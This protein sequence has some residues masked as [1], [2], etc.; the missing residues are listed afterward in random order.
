M[1]GWAACCPLVDRAN[2]CHRRA[3][4][5]ISRNLCELRA[6]WASGISS[7]N[8]DRGNVFSKG[9]PAT[10]TD[11]TSTSPAV[12]FTILCTS[13]HCGPMVIKSELTHPKSRQLRPPPRRR[14]LS[15]TS[16]RLH[17]P[18]VRW[19]AASGRWR[20]GTGKWPLI[21]PQL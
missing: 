7:G 3:G 9:V 18:R 8:A 15:R 13:N 17:F 6:H 5:G 11:D 10:K 19:T 12:L 2:L 16:C 4:P 21:I 14:F 20:Y 1:P